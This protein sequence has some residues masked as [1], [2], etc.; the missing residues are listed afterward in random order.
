MERY[1]YNFVQKQVT[2]GK[3]LQNWIIATHKSKIATFYCSSITAGWLSSKAVHNKIP[4]SRRIL[5]HLSWDERQNRHLWRYNSTWESCN[6]KLFVE[7]VIINTVLFDQRSVSMHLT[8][9]TCS[10]WTI[11][12]C[13]NLIWEISNMESEYSL[14][15]AAGTICLLRNIVRK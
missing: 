4:M 8:R 5:H 14:E 9:T 15:S 10:A 2:R 13:R 6:T 12:K 11:R 3:M 7:N 1:W